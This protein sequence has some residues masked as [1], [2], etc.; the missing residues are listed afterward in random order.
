MYTLHKAKEEIDAV[1][2]HATDIATHVLTLS[3]DL[4]A[5]LSRFKKDILDGIDKKFADLE[6]T[7]HGDTAVLDSSAVADLGAKVSLL[8]STKHPGTA[9]GSGSVPAARPP[10]EAHEHE[11][12]Q[13]TNGG[14]EHEDRPSQGGYDPNAEPQSEGHRY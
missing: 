13:H 1:A 7:I 8:S 6:R 10:V 4:H 2:N 14:R 9:Q 11:P 3:D 12:A 5:E